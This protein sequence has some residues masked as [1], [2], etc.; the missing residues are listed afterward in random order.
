VRVGQAVAGSLRFGRG[1]LPVDTTR[2][3]HLDT[4]PSPPA[5]TNDR[6]KVDATY[7]TAAAT[8][9]DIRWLGEVHCHGLLLRQCGQRRGARVKGSMQVA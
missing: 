4:L 1:V 6:N 9:T 8:A 2:L 7:A 5:V 3:Q